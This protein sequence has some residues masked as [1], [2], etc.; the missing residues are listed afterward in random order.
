MQAG[1]LLGWDMKL[2]G[3]TFIISFFVFAEFRGRRIKTRSDNPAIVVWFCA[4]RRPGHAAFRPFSLALRWAQVV[5]N[6]GSLGRTAAR[7][8]STPLPF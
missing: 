5:A 7:L 1:A 2:G 3:F 8:S 6:L 4:A